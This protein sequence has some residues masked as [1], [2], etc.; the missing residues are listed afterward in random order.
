MLFV[1]ERLMVW[2]RTAGLTN[3]RKIYGTIKDGLPK[4]NYKVVINNQ[5]NVEPFRGKKFFVMT[6]TNAL[7]G[8]NM[9]LAT[10]Y[11]VFGT[12]CLLFAFVF[13][14]A[15]VRKQVINPIA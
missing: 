11:I 12:F 1:I 8:N 5:F 9:F 3:F 6:T 4:G 13:F 10:S 2:M 15:T 14:V 7:G